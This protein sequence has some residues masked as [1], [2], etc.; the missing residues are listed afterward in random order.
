MRLANLQY[1][2]PEVYETYPDF[3][4]CMSLSEQ[5]NSLLLSLPTAIGNL[6]FQ[7]C[8]MGDALVFAKGIRDN[9]GQPFDSKP[10]KSLTEKPD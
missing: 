2:S 3:S 8:N 9:L 4:R 6:T 1:D 7:L 10:L 5:A